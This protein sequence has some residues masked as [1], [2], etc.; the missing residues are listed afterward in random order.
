MKPTKWDPF[1]ELFSVQERI[2]L[3]FDESMS[4]TDIHGEDAGIKHWFPLVDIYETEDHIILTAELPGIDKNDIKVEI[5]E[6]VLIL[7]GERKF[8]KDVEEENYHRMERSYGNFQRVF[9]IPCM[10]NEVKAKY[11]NGVLEVVL[12]KNKDPKPKH[13]KVENK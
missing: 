8:E 1:K 13:I 2:N 3:F 12:L 10:K 7:K 9:T 11:H 6:D 5:K 4:R